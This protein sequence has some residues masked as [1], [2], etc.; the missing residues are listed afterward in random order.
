[1]YVGWKNFDVS[2]QGIDDG[3]APLITV[4]LCS[5]KFTRKELRPYRIHDIYSAWKFSPFQEMM[6]ANETT[7]TK[8]MLRLVWRPLGMAPTV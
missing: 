8:N 6:V 4:G 1:M 5:R 3:R 2:V 7:V